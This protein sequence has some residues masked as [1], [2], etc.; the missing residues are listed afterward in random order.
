MQQ[1]TQPKRKRKLLLI[2]AALAMMLG[3]VAVADTVKAERASAYVECRGPDPQQPY[4]AYPFG[5][6][7]IIGETVCH[8]WPN[9]ITYPVST[10]VLQGIEPWGAGNGYV[11][12]NPDN[13]CSGV[14]WD[15]AP[16]ACGAYFRTV[17][18]F[19]SNSWIYGNPWFFDG[20]C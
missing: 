14:L 4:A 1:N 2:F 7:V 6:R 3:S 9:A 18:Y 16:S 10:C 17:T 13:T 20:A 11:W 12:I 19:G 5:Y 8:G 15:A